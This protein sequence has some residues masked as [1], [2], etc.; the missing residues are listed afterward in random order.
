MSAEKDISRSGGGRGFEC[1]FTGCDAQ[2][3]LDCGGIYYKEDA[4]QEC[5][6]YMGEYIVEK[7]VVSYR[8]N[9]SKILYKLVTVLDSNITPRALAAAIIMIDQLRGRSGH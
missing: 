1:G 8:E 6:V 3:R 4:N 9:G 5:P 7:L 2:N